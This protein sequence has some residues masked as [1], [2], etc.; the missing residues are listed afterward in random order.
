MEGRIDLSEFKLRT[1]RHL[2]PLCQIH[3]RIPCSLSA[4]E[5]GALASHSAVARG[6]HAKCEFE[7]VEEDHPDQAVIS[8]RS[9]ASRRQ[10]QALVAHFKFATWRSGSSL[11]AKD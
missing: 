11:F 10:H 9:R 2:Q 5:T 6:D 4:G 3:C 7:N 1:G 8:L